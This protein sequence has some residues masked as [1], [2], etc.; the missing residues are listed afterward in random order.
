MEEKI[1]KFMPNQAYCSHPPHCTL[2]H[3]KIRNE[4]KALNELDNILCQKVSFE[5]KVIETGIF[6]NDIATGGHTLYLKI[7][8]DKKLYDLQL[9]VAKSLKCI[10]KKSNN[11]NYIM[12][13]D[14]LKESFD[15]YGFP[16]IG[17]HWI[18]HLTIASLE[19]DKI[20]P[21]ITDFQS[22]QPNCILKVNNLSC[23]RVNGDDH[24]KLKNY[25][26]L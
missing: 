10:I 13:N 23:W 16:F 12:K 14:V 4:E 17:S 20:N 19:V 25:K 22:W 11:P 5:L 18:P 7:K 21:I 3:T 24:Q 15:N 2:I 9:S 1:S 26:L 8:S 6:W